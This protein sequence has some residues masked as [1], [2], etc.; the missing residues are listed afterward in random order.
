MGQITRID[1]AKSHALI[2]TETME[3]YRIKSLARYE[4]MIK[5]GLIG[6]KCPPAKYVTVDG[7]APQALGPAAN[8]RGLL[9]SRKR[10]F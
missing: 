8:A 9:G 3:R 2:W 4:A 7:V 5:A 1:L 6:A 10:A